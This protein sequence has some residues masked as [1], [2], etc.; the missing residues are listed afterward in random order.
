MNFIT[1]QQGISFVYVAFIIAII[2]C[3][4]QIDVSVGAISSGG[5]VFQDN[6]CID[7]LV[8]YEQILTKLWLTF[9]GFIF[10]TGYFLQDND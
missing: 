7:P 6:H 5:C 1:K 4:W 2:F 9:I 3:L 10:F 8:Y